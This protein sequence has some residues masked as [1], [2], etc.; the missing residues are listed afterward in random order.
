MPPSR[1]IEAIPENVARVLGQLKP[2]STTTADV[3]AFANVDEYSKNE[4]NLVEAYRQDLPEDNDNNFI[5]DVRAGLLNDLRQEV[6]ELAV[7]ERFW[8]AAEKIKT[9]ISNQRGLATRQDNNSEEIKTLEERRADLLMQC[10]TVRCHREAFQILQHLMPEATTNLEKAILH[11]KIGRL[12]AVPEFLGEGDKRDLGL[13]HL[14]MAVSL[15]QKLSP[16]PHDI[17][18]SATQ[19]IAQVFKESGNGQMAKATQ[20][21]MRIVMEERGLHNWQKASEVCKSAALDWCG[22]KGYPVHSDRFRYIDP[23]RDV[24]MEG[25]AKGRTPLHIAAR[26]GKHKVVKEML[27]EVDE[28]AVD[29]RDASGSTPLMEAAKACHVATVEALL[30][31]GANAD[32]ADAEGMTAL[33]WAADHDWQAEEGPA[34]VQALLAQGKP[35]LIDR[36]DDARGETALHLACLRYHSAT[37]DCLLA[38]DADPNLTNQQGQSPLLKAISESDSQTAEYQSIARDIARALL[39]AGADP[40]IRDIYGNTALCIVCLRKDVDAVSLLL[41]RASPSL[42]PRPSMS[43]FATSPTSALAPTISTATTVRRSIPTDVNQRGKRGETP[44]IIAVNNLHKG[45]VQKLREHGANPAVAD[46]SQRTA[47][48]RAKTLGALGELR[49]LPDKKSQAQES[50]AGKRKPRRFS[51]LTKSETR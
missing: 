50:T 30:T 18:C 24:S 42:L 40:N 14:N 27:A 36:R 33:H 16:F 8:Q 45:I 9:I 12:Y 51:W 6:D 20:Q 38:Q 1:S 44:L 19:L 22:R 21:K 2:P 5:S 10:S 25:S 3:D 11:W 31:Y 49:G 41:D 47:W 48:D 34:V 29:V 37:V 26:E 17:F 32:N 15:L 7:Q 23:V 13:W 35:G 39:D 28:N 43:S 4:R 46:E